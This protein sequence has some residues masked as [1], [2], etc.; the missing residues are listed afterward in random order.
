VKK[1]EKM[2]VAD[3]LS[4]LLAQIEPNRSELE[5]Y[6][7]HRSSISGALESSFP[8]C[9]TIVIGSHSRGSAISGSSD[10]DLLVRLPRVEAQWGG[11]QVSSQTVLKN[12]RIELQ[13]RFPS[14]GIGRDGQ[15]VVVN[16]VNGN[17]DIDVVPAVFKEM[18]PKGPNGAKRPVYHIPDGDNGWMDTSP[19]AHADYIAA[20]DARAGGKLKYTIQLLKHWRSCRSPRTPLLS[21]HL[22]LLLASEGLCAGVK[23]Y[24]ACLTDAFSLLASRE[25]R[26][27]QDP[28][29]VSGLVPVAYTR[30]QQEAALRNVETARD[31][32]RRAV[33][34]EGRRDLTEAYRQWDLVF[35]GGF[36]KR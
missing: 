20:A 26:A 6:A 18:A 17:F 1:E 12:V 16:F 22:E 27:L 29:G 35:N 28:V 14:T 30:S 23:S 9:K 15:A 31:H 19:D 5:K 8:G 36:P 7:G 3:R 13:S 11:S 10:L 24:A 2:S 25:L 32:A 21:F 34:A 4:S 33:E